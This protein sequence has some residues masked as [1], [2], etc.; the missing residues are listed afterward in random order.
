MICTVRG[1]DLEQFT[2]NQQLT[3]QQEADYK[4]TVQNCYVCPDLKMEIESFEE[5]DG[6]YKG[7]IEIDS[8]ICRIQFFEIGNK[9]YY[10]LSMENGTTNQL[11]ED[12]SSNL[13]TMTLTQKDE[14][15][16]AHVTDDFFLSPQYFPE[17]KVQDSTFEFVKSDSTLG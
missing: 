1:S 12:T 10:V 11:K 16:I 8:K 3:F 15:L 6:Y 4:L 14:M 13:I 7:K 17:W 5:I 2:E 9:N